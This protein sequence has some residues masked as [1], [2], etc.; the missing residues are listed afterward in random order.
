MYRIVQFFD[1]F[2]G[3]Y[4]Y[5]LQRKSWLGFWVTIEYD[6]HEIAYKGWCDFYEIKEEDIIPAKP[7]T[8]SPG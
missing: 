3:H 6:F 8:P 2:F 1:N 7:P 4:A 5:K